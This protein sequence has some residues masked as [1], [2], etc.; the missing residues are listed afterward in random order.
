MSYSYH[1]IMQIINDKHYL[2]HRSNDRSID[3]MVSPNIV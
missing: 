1:L 2:S 3:K